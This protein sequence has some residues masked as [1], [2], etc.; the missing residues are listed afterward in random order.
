MN[1]QFHGVGRRIFEDG[2]Y[3][4]GDWL[5]GIRQGQGTFESADGMSYTGEWFNGVI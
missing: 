4:L 1:D 5:N 2:A 3:Y